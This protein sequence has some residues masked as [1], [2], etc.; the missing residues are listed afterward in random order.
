MV[1]SEIVF[2]VPGGL[3]NQ[4]F[5][6][7]CAVYVAQQNDFSIDM[8]FSSVDRSHHMTSIPLLSMHILP[9]RLHIMKS[10][11]A[12]RTEHS[13]L[14][15]LREL[16]K[17]IQAHRNYRNY[18]NFLPGL[19]SREHLDEFFEK[20]FKASKKALT[21][22]G[23][24]GDFGFYDALNP[25][26]REVRVLNPS[27]YFLK[28][29]EEFQASPFA[30]VH[31]RLGDFLGLRDSVGVLDK[32]YYEAAFKLS[33]EKGIRIFQVF[34]NDEHSSKSIFHNWG[35]D[36]GELQWIDSNVLQDP[37]ENLLLMGSGKALIASNSTFSFWAGKLAGENCSNIFFPSEFR[38]DGLTQVKNIPSSWTPI[39]SK[40][41]A[42]IPN[43]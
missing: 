40:W 32:Q 1:K 4:L 42:G 35:F 27:D 18:R 6:Y 10:S 19:D 39:E 21:I 29:R 11:L 33:R 30:A 3:G 38:R 23:Y 14:T 20:E 22:D 24:F 5:S 34:T 15:Q 13:K 12:A 31:H 43:T 41:D 2:K 28:L 36:I 9:S 37:M 25:F 16:A 8:D 7:Y 17:R 26:S